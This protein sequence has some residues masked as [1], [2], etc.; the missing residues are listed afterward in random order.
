MGN[1]REHELHS[2]SALNLGFIPGEVHYCGTGDGNQYGFWRDDRRIPASRLHTSILDAYDAVGRKN[3]TN[4]VVVVSPDSHSL[5][6]SPTF[7]KNMTHIVGNY[8]PTRMNMRARFEM[9]TAF[10]PMLTISGYGNLFKNLYFMH[11]TA[12]A[13]LVGL[14]ITGHRN[15]FE[16]VHFLSPQNALQGSESGWIGIHLNTVAE[17]YFKNCFFGNNTIAQDEASTLFKM[18]T[19][20]GV[21]IFENCVF[22]QRITIGQTDPYLFTIDNTTDT[23]LCIFKN[24]D[25]IADPGHGTPAVAFKFSGSAK[26]RAMF[27]GRCQFYN[28]ASPAGAAGDAYC[29]VA[30]VLASTDDDAGMLALTPTFGS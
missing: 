25:F 22:M 1:L 2:A 23:G 8:P 21:A 20:C 10:T 28:Y 13:D 17:T 14:L 4:S 11:G 19:G 15:T 9:S 3:A 29:L 18:S 5:A 26:G 6:A 24:C 12:A 27:D 30:R 7:D 16:N